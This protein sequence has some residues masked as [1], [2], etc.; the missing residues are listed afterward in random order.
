M[1][2]L[3]NPLLSGLLVLLFLAPAV[4][5]GQSLDATVQVSAVVQ[6]SPPRITL[7]WSPY[8]N[9]SGY[10][11]YRKL[12]TDNAWGPAV[13]SLP[14]L[15]TTWTDNNV[16]VNVSYEYKIVRSTLNL[17]A[18]YGYVNAGIQLEMVENRGKLVLLVDNF[19]STSLSSALAQLQTD[20]EA[21]GWVVLRHD[22]SRTASV[23][24]IRNIVL[25]RYNADPANVKAVFI[26]GHVPVPRSGNFAP[27]GHGD[28]V[29]A[30]PADV[31]YGEMNGAWTDASVNNPNATYTWNRNT[32]GDGKLDQTVIPAPVELMVGRVDM[33]DMP[34]FPANETTLLGNYLNKLH[35]WKVKEFTAQSR[36]LVDDNF[37][38]ASAAMASSGYRN[39]GPLV[40]PAN[41]AAVDYFASMS[42]GSY[43]WS[44]G[45][46]GG[47]WTGANGIGTTQNFVT[48]N[49]QGVFTMLFG[50]Y[51]GDW[52]MQNNFMRASLAT[53]RT[54]TCAWAGIPHWY[55]HHMGMGETIG[56]GTRLSQN[57]G[58]GLYTPANPNAGQVHI[59]LL[60]DPTLR[61]NMV[62]PPANLA[63]TAAGSTVN[64]TWGASNDGVIGYHVYRFDNATQTWVRRTTTAVTGT[65]YGDNAQ[66]LGGTLRYMVKALKLETTP[67]G[68]Y[69]NLSLGISGQVVLNSQATDCLGVVGGAAV[70]GS[71][72]SDGNPCTTG[73]VWT[74]NCQCVGT[75]LV[76]NDNNACTT[77][78]CVNGTCVFTPLPDSDG[79]GIC[80]AQDNCPNVAG[81]IGSSCNDGNPCT[82]N[83]VLNANCQCVGTP[84]VC[85]DN[86][87]CTTDACVSGNCV[88]TPLPDSDGDGICNAQDNCPNVAGQIGSACND[89][90]ACTFNDVL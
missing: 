13:A 66:G 45:C 43:L 33:Y 75:P 89:N 36:A 20:L 9:V 62:R 22:V 52:D 61:M 59:S 85:N 25:S 49:L 73:D 39:F 65:T 86:N 38:G 8:L 24:S 68:T 32:P 84:R 90:N 58:G 88:F 70:P 67:S 79:D 5:K 31:Y 42:N 46:G 28:H 4:V 51:F 34:A 12:K 19:Y 54:L 47:W 17:G 1:P 81:Q 63:I 16:A 60:G 30:W 15:A 35:Q 3:R 27:D 78:A 53:G 74:A 77:D 6:A 7:N 14:L 69:Y 71:S 57:N 72:C 55:V 50:S 87:A 56:Y 82:L 2:F 80:N 44:Y 11:I 83:D 48:S 26:V 18:G 21:D 29:G 41:V 76:C 10:Q 23:S 37:S 40:G 64:L